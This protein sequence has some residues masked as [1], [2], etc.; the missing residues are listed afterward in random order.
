MILM[1]DLIN[2]NIYSKCLKIDNLK[3]KFIY[4]IIIALKFIMLK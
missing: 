1:T 2:Y 3:N 4:I